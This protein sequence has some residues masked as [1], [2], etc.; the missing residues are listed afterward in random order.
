MSPHYDTGSADCPLEILTSPC[1]AEDSGLK[2]V[3]PGERALV[4]GD[5]GAAAYAI[6]GS[7]ED[8]RRFA[9][10]V[11]AEV[12]QAL[13]TEAMPAEVDGMPVVSAFRRLP[14]YGRLNSTWLV[15]LRETLDPA[16]G[17]KYRLCRVRRSGAAGQWEVTEAEPGAESLS[18][19]SA[20]LWFARVV[21]IDATPDD[22]PLQEDRHLTRE[23]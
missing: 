6:V 22:G 12:E 18:W 8:L 17:N 10:R 15:I 7:P 11:T 3:G 2:D 9:G 23:T 20:A 19:A 21:K 13:G 14:A 1:A 16:G 5:P 4:I